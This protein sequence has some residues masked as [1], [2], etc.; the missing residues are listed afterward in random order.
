MIMA[1]GP[2][3]LPAEAANEPQDRHSAGGGRPPR[4]S[5]MA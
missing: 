5:E 3:H 4:Q 2:E 1:A